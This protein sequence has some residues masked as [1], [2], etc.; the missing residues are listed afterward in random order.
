[1][2]TFS[3]FDRDFGLQ[4]KKFNTY[5]PFKK[6]WVCD[7][8]QKTFFLPKAKKRCVLGSLAYKSR[9]NWSAILFLVTFCCVNAVGSHQTWFRLRRTL[10]MIKSNHCWWDKMKPAGMS[11]IVRV[12]SHFFLNSKFFFLKMQKKKG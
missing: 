3:S 4:K 7:S 5:L 10:L 11:G 9:V 1:M 6:L 2:S 12:F 8:K